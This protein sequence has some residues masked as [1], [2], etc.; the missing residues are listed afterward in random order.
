MTWDIQNEI[1]SFSSTTRVNWSEM[2]RK[3]N[4]NIPGKNVLK[5]TSK[6]NTSSREHN[7]SITPRIPRHKCLLRGGQIF[8]PYLPTMNTVEEEHKSLMLFGELNI[9]NHA[10]PFPLPS[11]L[12]QKELS[13]DQYKSRKRTC[14]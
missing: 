1:E 2:A 14:I 7:P 10:Y 9:V 5:Q 8:M 6:S 11:S 4:Y 12:L 13:L 3:Y